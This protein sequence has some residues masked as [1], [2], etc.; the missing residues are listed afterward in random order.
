MC[1]RNIPHTAEAPPGQAGGG[2]RPLDDITLPREGGGPTVGAGH[3]PAGRGIRGNQDRPATRGEEQSE[4]WR[5][6][7]LPA[8]TAADLS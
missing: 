3:S 7:D 5:P 8:C 4:R 2:P 6:A 1:N